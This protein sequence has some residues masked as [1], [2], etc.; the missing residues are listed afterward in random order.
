MD[1]S[2]PGA[3]SGAGKTDISRSGASTGAAGTDFSRS[4][5]AA[6]LLPVRSKW[7]ASDREFDRLMREL[8]DLEE[9]QLLFPGLWAP[10][11]EVKLHLVQEAGLAHSAV[12]VDGEDLRRLAGRDHPADL[13]D[14]LLTLQPVEEGGFVVE[15]P[16]AA[17]MIPRPGRIQPA[18]LGRPASRVDTARIPC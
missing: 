10:A 3:S 1:I 16:Y 14:E 11:G 9:R 6:E 4:G 17:S 5:A 7:L 13:G 15:R 18:P 2:R 8:I 12:A